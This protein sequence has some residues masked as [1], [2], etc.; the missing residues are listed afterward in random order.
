MVHFDAREEVSSDSPVVTIVE[1]FRKRSV[2]L[3]LP[4]TYTTLLICIPPLKQI[5]NYAITEFVQG[6]TRLIPELLIRGVIRHPQ[7]KSSITRWGIN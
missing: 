4:S 6:R 3:L 7:P 2:C 1:N 5:T